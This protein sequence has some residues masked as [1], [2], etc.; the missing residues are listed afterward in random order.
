MISPQD[1]KLGT[2]ELFALITITLG[3]K[4]T[5]MTATLL[6]KKTAQA[7]WMIPLVSGLIMLIP[8]TCTLIL[9]KHYGD[10]NIIDISYKVTGNF[11]GFLIGMT[12]F[13]AAYAATVVD[14]RSYV[15]IINTMYFESTSSTH[16]FFV[17]VGSSYFLANR[18]LLAIGRTALIAFPYIKVSLFFIIVLLWSDLYFGYLF[19]L[20][21]FG[22]KEIAFQGASYASITSDLLFFSIL[23]PFFK[24]YKTF[25]KATLLGL[26]VST[27]ELM[28][29]FAVYIMYFDYPSIEFIS[30]PFHEISRMV[31]FGRYV[32]HIEALFFAF[33]SVASLIRF[34]VYL[35][36]A[37]AFFAYTAKIKEF[38]PL[39]LPFA[40]LTI[41][42]GLLPENVVHNV[43][44]LRSNVILMSTSV[45]LFIIPITLLI[46]AKLRGEFK[47]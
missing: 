17:L 27:L 28:I 4:F 14:S 38:E 3:I 46:V 35:Y 13:L 26:A 7:A 2:R 11:F 8:L 41:M 1:R 25:K 32:S 36:I 20:T 43:L 37:T 19:P 39:I 33:W 12:L 34:A 22:L 42:L 16:L 21:G 6:Y 5:D 9:L 31:T 15:D 29:F 47:K 40:G 18:G 10:R 44:L 45:L 23:F 30:Y 24:D